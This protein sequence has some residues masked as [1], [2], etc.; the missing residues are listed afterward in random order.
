MK[1]N[2]TISMKKGDVIALTENGVIVKWIVDGPQDMNITGNTNDNGMS[3]YDYKVAAP[4]IIIPKDAYKSETE[5]LRKGDGEL[6][7]SVHMMTTFTDIGGHYLKIIRDG[8][9]IKQ[10][11]LHNG[12]GDG[13]YH[14]RFADGILMR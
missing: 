2:E 10:I 13:R 11:H 4:C 1:F 12:F 5:K 6:F 8:M 9:V 7:G 14:L 3:I